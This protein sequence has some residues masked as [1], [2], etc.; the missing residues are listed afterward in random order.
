MCATI[1]EFVNNNPRSPS[2]SLLDIISY[3]NNTFFSD[4]SRILFIINWRICFSK[5]WTLGAGL[6]SY[7]LPNNDDDP[8]PNRHG[9]RT[10]AAGVQ[11]LPAGQSRVP[12]E[13]QQAREGAGQDQPADQTDYQGGELSVDR[14][15]K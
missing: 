14:R 12:R 9:H 4:K 5:S 3:N 11:G 15:K 10:A 2:H 13:S 7:S 8:P 1:R 6:P